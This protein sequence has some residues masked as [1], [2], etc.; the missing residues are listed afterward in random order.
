MWPPPHDPQIF[1]ALE[2][3]AAPLMAFIEGARS[4]GHRVTPTHIVG[5]AIGYALQCVPEL[6]VRI[7]RGRARRRRSVDIFFIT[8]VAKGQDLS[9]VKISDVPNKPAVVVATEL[10]ERSTA[11]KRG[12]DRDFSRTKRLMNAL[13]PW[14]LRGALRATAFVT[15]DLG[16]DVPA[17]SLHREPFGSAMVTSVGMFGL[18]QGFA[19]LAWMYDV[20][21]L[22][23]VGELV[24]RAVVLDGRVVARDVLPL[25]M[26][27]DHRYVDGWQ[28][29]QGLKA[30]REYLAAPERFE[31]LSA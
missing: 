9:G 4:Q 20:P 24:E 26:T 10:F 12:D 21:L 13:P 29:S 30:L 19:P 3:D 7:G 23:L 25:T 27:I 22:V 14:L 5:R 11:M 1:G 8:S 18:P 31:P 2:V 17:L 6:N 16:L 15:E 28:I